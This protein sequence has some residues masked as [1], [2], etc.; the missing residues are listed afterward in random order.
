MSLDRHEYQN[1]QDFC[2]LSM[3]ILMSAVATK[4]LPVAEVCE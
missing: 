3:A 1:Q 2:G 4:S